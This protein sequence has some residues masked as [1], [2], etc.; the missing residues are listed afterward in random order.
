MSGTIVSSKYQVVIPKAVRERVGL[1]P[2]TRLEIFVE[3][4][5]IHLVPVRPLKELYGI[6]K[7]VD[8]GEVRD[9]VDRF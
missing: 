7:G 8:V 5:S 9:H 6:L 4:N 3:G 1:K 2:G